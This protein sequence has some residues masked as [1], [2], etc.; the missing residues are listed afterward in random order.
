M[1]GGDTENLPAAAVA[2]ASSSPAA[3]PETVRESRRT[4]PLRLRGP[5]GSMGGDRPRR[6]RRIRWLV[7]AAL[8]AILVVIVG[9]VVS[10]RNPRVKTPHLLGL[11][12]RQA[13]AKAEKLGFDPIFR[14]IASDT[15]AGTVAR[16]RPYPGKRVPKGIPILVLLSRGP[17]VVPL[18]SPP[19]PSPPSAHVPPGHEKKHGHGRG[20]KH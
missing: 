12:R 20:G 1:V 9:V 14:L 18:P 15:P 3:A 13:K 11:N 19:A 4:M 8:V 2:A 6:E 7:G 17:T 5:I 10:G 16:Q